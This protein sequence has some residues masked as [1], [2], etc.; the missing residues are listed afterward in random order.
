[1]TK[2]AIVIALDDTVSPEAMLEKVERM[3]GVEFGMPGVLAGDADSPMV[4][5]Q[6][7]EMPKPPDASKLK[8]YFWLSAEESPRQP[9]PR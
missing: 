2:R 5:M 8:Q 3:K 4:F 7:P 6:D 9:S 1:M